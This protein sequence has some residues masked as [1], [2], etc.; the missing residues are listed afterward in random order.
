[1]HFQKS[2]KDREKFIPF[3]TVWP[4]DWHINKCGMKWLR[5]AVYLYG[6]ENKTKQKPKN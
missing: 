4:R 5:D 3:M 2:N 6:E 1:M